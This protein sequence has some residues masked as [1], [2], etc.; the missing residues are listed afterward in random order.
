MQDDKNVFAGVLAIDA[1]FEDLTRFLQTNYKGTNTV[2]AIFEQN[3]PHYMIASSTGSSSA[4][5]VLAEDETK[6]CPKAEINSG[7]C[8]AIRIKASDLISSENEIDHIVS[9][10]FLRQKEEGFP[11][12]ELVSTKTNEKMLLYA[13]QSK[14][15]SIEEASLDWTIMIMTPVETE[16]ADQIVKG[17]TLFGAL[18]T[19]A[20]LG[21]VICA[22]LA[23]TILY[24]RNKREVIVSDW[25]FMTISVGGCALL[26]LSCLSFLGPNTDAL[27]LTRMWLVHWFFVFAL[28]FLFVKTYRVYKLLGSGYSRVT[29]TH[30]K[31]A[32]LTLPLIALQTLILLIFTFV[33]PNKR[34]EIIENQ[35]SNITHRYVCSHDTQAFFVVMLTYEGGLILVGCVLA[36]K[37][38]NLCDE[39]NES[40]QIIFAMYDLA[41]IGSVLLIVSKAVA[42]SQGAQRVL[43]AVGVFWTTCF[44]SL[45]FVLPRLIPSQGAQRVL[46]AVGVFWTTCFASLVFVLPRLIRVRRRPS[47][48][49]ITSRATTRQ[50]TSRV[51]VSGMPSQGNTR[52]TFVQNE[53]I[54]SVM[55]PEVGNTN[56]ATEPSSEPEEAPVSS[57]DKK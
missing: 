40:K 11:D 33:D 29:I 52:V 12:A 53:D 36:F 7:F 2:V 22:F 30:A 55:I 32:R 28:S 45:V 16:G 56:S 57:S 17:D 5:T 49:N 41:V 26:N 50:G 14:P 1:T 42:T 54:S 23:G 19:V 46:F 3:E 44:A 39:F 9:S 34:N 21:F 6:P 47:Q 13:T 15:F 18:I 38:R 24:Y 37:T 48:S 51:T 4:K 43:F 10:A 8:K 35:G 25:R 27:C 20:V 31:A